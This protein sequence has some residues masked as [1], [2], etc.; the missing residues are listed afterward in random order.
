MLK[1]VRM[2]IVQQIKIQI[3]NIEREKVSIEIGIR[4]IHKIGID[5]LELNKLHRA[6]VDKVKSK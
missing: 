5:E 1:R 4:V 2:L 6:V 3:S